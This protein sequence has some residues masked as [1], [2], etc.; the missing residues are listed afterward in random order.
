MSIVLFENTTDPWYVLDSKLEHDEWHGCLTDLVELAQVKLHGPCQL[1][2][3]GDLVVRFIVRVR[4]AK[5]S[6]EQRSREIVNANNRFQWDFE[7]KQL[8]QM[9]HIQ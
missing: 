9:K 7:Y 2:D 4:V 5:V 1:F 3:V 6:K 8:F